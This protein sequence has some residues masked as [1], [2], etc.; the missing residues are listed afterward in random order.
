MNYRQVVGGKKCF[1]LK[2]RDHDLNY[3]LWPVKKTI[4][5]GIQKI[6]DVAGEIA[7]RLR[8]LMGPP[9]KSA[10]ACGQHLQRWND[11]P[12]NLRPST[13]PVRQ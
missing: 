7:G 9:T 1:V 10:L 2:G 6:F 13:M 8:R 5:E 3:M 11:S 12:M 4:S